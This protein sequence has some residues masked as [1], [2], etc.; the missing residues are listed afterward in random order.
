M[1]FIKLALWL[2]ILNRMYLNLIKFNSNSYLKI[3][4]YNMIIDNNSTEY[5]EMIEKNK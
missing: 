1:K 5:F 4:F 3:E 2:M